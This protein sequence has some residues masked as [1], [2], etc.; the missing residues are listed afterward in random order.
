MVGVVVVMLLP[1]SM[2]SAVVVAMELLALSTSNPSK[3]S[4]TSFMSSPRSRPPPPLLLLL[5]SG[6]SFFLDFLDFFFLLVGVPE[7]VEGVA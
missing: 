3:S 1:I 7:E 5:F 6:L 2:F 4:P